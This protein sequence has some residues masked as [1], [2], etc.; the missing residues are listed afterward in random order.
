M[1]T[2]AR[3]AALFA[4]VA[5]PPVL[6]YART[7]ALFAPVAQ[8]PV[9]TYAR[10]AALFAL[11]VPPP[12]RAAIGRR[13][14][15][16]ARLQ[17]VLGYAAQY[18][19]GIALPAPFGVERMLRAVGA[20]TPRAAARDNQLGL[21]LVGPCHCGQALGCDLCKHTWALAV[22]ERGLAIRVDG[23]REGLIRMRLSLARVAASS[24]GRAGQQAAP[25]MAQRSGR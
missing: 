23:A 5:Q 11:A 9:L 18:A 22:I 14:Q 19:P 1:L 10:T 24:R 8:P 25:C 12:V 2:Y 20:V 21:L 13:P 4:P 6:T 15:L 3:T 16:A 7:A 17:L